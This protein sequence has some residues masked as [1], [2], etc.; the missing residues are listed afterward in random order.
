M[1]S[2]KFEV[3]GQQVQYSAKLAARV[4]A[5]R[6]A[7]AVEI[8]AHPAGCVDRADKRRLHRGH[9]S[10]PHL[11]ALV[12]GVVLRAVADNHFVRP[13]RDVVAETT[14]GRVVQILD[15]VLAAVRSE[16]G[17]RRP[18]RAPELNLTRNRSAAVCQNMALDVTRQRERN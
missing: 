18:L 16:V 3:F 5:G 8:C 12:D 10:P 7:V 9:F 6:A 2:G 13:G 4:V 15:R 17:I 1:C 11:D 14:V